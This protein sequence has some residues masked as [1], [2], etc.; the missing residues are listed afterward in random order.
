M[1]HIPNNC[2]N[3]TILYTG[4]WTTGHRVRETG[5][6][7]LFLHRNGCLFAISAGQSLVLEKKIKY[8]PNNQTNT[9]YKTNRKRIDGIIGLSMFIKYLHPT[10]HQRWRDIARKTNCTGHGLMVLRLESA[11]KPHMGW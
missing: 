5:L 7:A 9:V 1:G 4:Q 2:G 3:G 10:S 11:L 6:Q 8:I